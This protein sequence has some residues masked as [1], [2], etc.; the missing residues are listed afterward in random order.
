MLKYF[1]LIALFFVPFISHG[2][3]VACTMEYAPVCGQPPM[4][5]CPVGM[6][7]IQAM[8]QPKTYGNT[9]MMNADKATLLHSGECAAL[10]TTGACTR[11]YMPVCGMKQI[12]C[13]TTPCDP[14]R[15]DYANRCTAEVDG[16]TDITD[17]T[18][19]MSESTSPII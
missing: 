10:P 18:C 8:P 16:A 15:T 2:A 5:V 17:G 12:Q 7:C 1:F 13:I 9:C 6:A 14:L 19:I 11:E 4:P 3:E